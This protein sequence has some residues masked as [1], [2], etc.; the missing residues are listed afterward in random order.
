MPQ[1][2]ALRPGFEELELDDELERRRRAMPRPKAKPIAR[3]KAQARPAPSTTPRPAKPGSSKRQRARP[4][5]IALVPAPALIGAPDEQYAALVR[6]VQRTL[7][8]TRR[9]RLP[10][11]GVL[12]P[13]TRSA[14]RSLDEATTGAEPADA[15]PPEESS[16]GSEPLDADASG[17]PASTAPEANPGTQTEFETLELDTPDFDREVGAGAPMPAPSGG[18][19]RSSRD[20]VRWI[21]GSLNQIMQAGLDLDGSLGPLTRSAI[22]SFQ[23]RAKLSV[24]GIVGPYTEAALIAAGAGAPPGSSAPSSPPYPSYGPS[25]GSRPTPPSSNQ[26]YPTSSD[27]TPL[28]NQGDPAWAARI[29]GRD[30]SFKAAGCLVTA[31]AMALSKVTRTLLLPPEIDRRLDENGGYSGDSVI[32]AALAEWNGVRITRA[33]PTAWTLDAVH[34]SLAAGCPVVLG[35]HYKEGPATDH[36][37]TITRRSSKGGR[38]VYHANDPAGGVPIE[39]YAQGDRLLGPKNYQSTGDAV[40]FTRP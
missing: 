33:W 18:T 14:L 37:I 40:F 9:L 26:R 8:R 29:L 2:E 34:R 30:R 10:E 16:S 13:A 32:W 27:G 19:S 22:R 36:W 3:P 7:N 39:L 12:G 28:F 15:S 24:D 6:W 31:I 11:D 21:Q 17:D 25:Q 38:N 4:P 20:Y 35:V 23:S 1:H 5:G